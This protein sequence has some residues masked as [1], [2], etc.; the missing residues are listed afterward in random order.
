MRGR[1][2]IKGTAAPG[3]QTRSAD[4]THSWLALAPYGLATF[5]TN[6]AS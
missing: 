2:S 3:A 6:R 1:F 4:E 5:S